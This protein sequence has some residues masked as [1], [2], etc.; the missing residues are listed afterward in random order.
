M[1]YVIFVQSLFIIVWENS[2]KNLVGKY[3]ENQIVY[4]YAIKTSLKLSGKI[5]EN[6]IAY[7][8]YCLIVNSYE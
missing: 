4:S 2:S 3:E 6:D 8:D 7:I 5:E 1:L